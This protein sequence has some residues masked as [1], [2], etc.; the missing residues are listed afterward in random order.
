MIF[1][2]TSGIGSRAIAA[3]QL[4]V[5]HAKER[6]LLSTMVCRVR[7]AAHHD[8]C[9]AAADLENPTSSSHHASSFVRNELNRRPASSAY[10]RMNSIR[11]SVE[12]SGGAPTS[13]PSMFL[14]QPSSLMH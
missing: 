13:M 14:N 11:V 4:A 12:G 5:Q 9:P 8:P 6:H 2:K 1:G 7:N 3:V 10:R